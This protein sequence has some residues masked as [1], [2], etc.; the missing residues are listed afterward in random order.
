MTKLE[1]TPKVWGDLLCPDSHL[2][3]RLVTLTSPSTTEPN[4]HNGRGNQNG[5][6][7]TLNR[8]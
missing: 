1:H 8:S 3:S 7:G 2:Q 5:V 6:S 4:H